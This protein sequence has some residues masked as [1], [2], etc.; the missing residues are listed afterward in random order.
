MRTDTAAGCTACSIREKSSMLNDAHISVHF[1]DK[2]K[3]ISL[4]AIWEV[5][6][7]N[8]DWNI[9]FPNLDCS[10]FSSVLKGK[11]WNNTLLGSLSFLS[12]YFPHHY[13]PVALPFDT[14]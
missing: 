3:H 7:S 5:V 2:G 6:D 14:M 9:G 10:L 8:L 4:K 13:S 11:L 1:E 12:K